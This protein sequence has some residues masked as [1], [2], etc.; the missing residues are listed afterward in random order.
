MAHIETAASKGHSA[1]DLG[2]ALASAIRSALHGIAH[3]KVIVVITGISIEDGQ[4]HVEVE[5]ILLDEESELERTRAEEEVLAKDF[6]SAEMDAED[7][8]SIMLMARKKEE[9]LHHM[10]ETVERIMEDNPLLD[11]AEIRDNDIYEYYMTEEIIDQL[12]GGREF[13]ID[14]AFHEELRNSFP[15]YSSNPTPMLVE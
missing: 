2:E 7:T 14:H 9:F 11:A 8:E 15:T 12:G 1:H 3:K 10:V 6:Y 4:Y 5:C 13:M